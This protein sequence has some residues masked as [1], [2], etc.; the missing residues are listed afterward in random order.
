MTTVRG[1]QLQIDWSDAGT[2]AGALE[3]A[4][5]LVDKAPVTV[6]WGRSVDTNTLTATTAELDFSMFNRTRSSDRYLSPEN[7]S[8]PIY[9][10]IYPGHAV[11]LLRTVAGG[12]TLYAE[13]FATSAGGWTAV[14]GGA[15]A[16]VATPSEDGDGALR[17][18][19]PGAV[20]V[21]GTTHPFQVP[22][23]TIA[24]SSF[25]LSMRV[26]AS[27][28]HSD[29][30]A[31]LD[32]YDSSGTNFASSV[33]ATT[34]LTAGAWTT[35]S[36]LGVTAPL[37]AVAF[38]PRLRLGSTPPAT[39]L[40]YVDNMSVAYTPL[41]AGQTYRLH[42]GILDDLSVDS[43]AAARTFTGKAVDAFGRINS[44]NLS[45]TLYQSV[46][47]G[48]AINVV[49]DAIGWPAADRAI[50]PGATVIPFWWE[51]GTDP[52]EAVTKL[53]N[54]EGPPAIAYVEGGT[55]V[56]RDRH[57][58]IRSAAS[59]TSGSL[60]TLIQPTGGASLASADGMFESGMLAGW[61]APS[62]G[63][64][65]VSNAQA[66]TG[67][68][69]GLL[70]TTGSPTQ[71]Y[72][73][74]TSITVT[75]LTSYRVVMWA[76]AASIT[77]NVQLAVDWFDVAGGYL[78]TSALTINLAANTWTLF[79]ATFTA[80]ASAATGSYGPTLSSSPTAGTAI[81][82][83]DLDIRRPASPG[84]DFKIEKSSFTYDHGLKSIVNT[85]TFS[86]GIRALTDLAEVWTSEDPIGMNSGD[87]QTFFVQPSDPVA[88]ALTP[89]MASGDIQVTAGA[90]TATIDRTSGQKFILTLTCVTTGA[91]SRLAL[92][93]FPAS[94][95]RTVQ[96][97]SSDQPSI[98]RYGTVSWPDEIPW[99]NAYDAQ[100]IADRIVAVYAGN[101]PRISFSIVNFN[102]RYESE[103]CSLRISDRV[104]VRNDV[105][106]INSDF[107]V[108]RVEHSVERWQLH[109][110]KIYCVAVEPVQAVNAFT[111]NVSG[112]GF[113]QGQ[114]A[115]QGIDNASTMFVFDAAG[116]GFDQGLFAN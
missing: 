2:F 12:G 100:A 111:F 14:S 82:V 36:T 71:T 20:A 4:A 6:G 61:G 23:M 115:V 37:G 49:L 31:V 86:V 77:N 108:E 105:L 51:E 93:G 58:R 110:L 59:N 114:F 32:W 104:T 57:H 106:G 83:D 5:N 45:T 39:T 87:T 47:T 78:S 95:V 54:S 97:S 62:G 46:R 72:V 103:I 109:R 24:P 19:P 27:V 48:T 7:T 22:I 94:V 74:A 76:R 65:A 16:R 66:H 50:D 73:R 70:T 13:T 96:V 55:F 68:W 64:F 15:V 63:T 43:T 88:G 112:K 52:A 90:F 30:A 116:Q 3:D 35:V 89:D 17:Y 25:V 10:K 8:G 67:T 69:S 81:W 113:D 91:V 21:V 80:P 92:R 79:D 9:G 98:S 1:W 85:A 99:A 29:A 102:D 60:Y 33:G 44:G 75:A 11:K 26:Q 34:V 53:V 84:Y 107:Y 28:T 56:F 42:R 40:F 101:R 38:I 41:D 18:T